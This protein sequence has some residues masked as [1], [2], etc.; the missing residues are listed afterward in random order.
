MGAGIVQVYAWPPYLSV[1]V[2]GPN[3]AS[4]PS[5][6]GTVGSAGGAA[7]V[8]GAV[9]CTSSRNR[10]PTPCS[11]CMESCITEKMLG[12]ILPYIVSVVLSVEA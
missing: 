10:W 2:T 6:A 3:A 5:A 12:D 7:A 8:V 9:I 11:C 1:K 4:A